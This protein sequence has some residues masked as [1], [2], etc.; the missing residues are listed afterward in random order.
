MFIPRRLTRKK[1]SCL[2]ITKDLHKLIK[3]RNRQYRKSKRKGCA[4]AERKYLMYR[5]IVRQ[6]LRVTHA[7]FVHR[8]FTDEQTAP[9]ELPKC[10]W[11]YV[12]HRRNNTASI[13][14]LRKGNVLITGAKERAELFNHQFVSVFSTPTDRIDYESETVRSKMPYITICKKGVLKQLKGLNHHKACRPDNLSPRV[15]SELADVLAEPLTALFQLSLDTGLVPK[16]WKQAIVT[17][18][19]K[20]GEK[21][22]PSNYRPISLTCV[23]S[24]VLEHV[25]T[26]QLMDYAENNFI[27]FHNQYGF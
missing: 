4:L 22:L 21:F 14:P 16:E 12:K 27:L 7:A 20:K 17:P 19:F 6:Q 11:T 13:G 2:W 1:D 26:S 25:V 18:I 15:L 3:R 8:L 23:V 5:A 10:F 9:G 24:K